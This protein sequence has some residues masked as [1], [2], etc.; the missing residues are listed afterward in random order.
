[1]ENLF[2]SLDLAVRIDAQALIH[3]VH[4]LG[5]ATA[6][7]TMDF[8]LE[9]EQ[10]RLGVPDAALED[11]RTLMPTQPLYAL[12]GKPGGGKS[13]RDWTVILPVDVIERRFEGP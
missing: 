6:A 12:G 5:K 8:W 10:S 13:A 3:D 4:A 1:M 7:D 2:D 11:L 9:R